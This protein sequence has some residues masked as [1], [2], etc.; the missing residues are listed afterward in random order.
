M[1]PTLGVRGKA[2]AVKRFLSIQVANL[3]SRGSIFDAQPSV[4]SGSF[5]KVAKHVHLALSSSSPAHACGHEADSIF[6]F[7]NTA[8]IV[9]LL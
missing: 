8:M 1:S 6:F 2:P 7:K 3:S 5:G 4:K 9:H